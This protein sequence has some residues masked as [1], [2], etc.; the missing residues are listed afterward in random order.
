MMKPQ[1]TITLELITRRRAEELLALNTANRPINRKTV[2]SFASDMVAGRWIFNAAPVLVCNK[3][4][5]RD[6][7]HF[8][9]AIVVTEIPQWAIVVV[10]IDP[11]A[12]RTIDTGGKARTLTDVLK[13]LGIP[14]TSKV[15][16]AVVYETVDFN[17]AAARRSTDTEKFDLI[18]E[19]DEELLKDLQQ[20]AKAAQA[21]ELGDRAIV[22]ACFR[23]LKQQKE[24]RLQITPW[25]VAT[26]G[27]DPRDPNFDTELSS[28][29]ARRLREKKK[30]RKHQSEGGPQK[31]DLGL[32]KMLLNACNEY[33]S[34]YHPVVLAEPL[35]GPATHQKRASYPIDPPRAAT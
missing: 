13:L 26:L 10:G 16:Q 27:G 33:V 18:E 15:A 28:S 31:H 4:V 32:V 12:I 25:L 24:Y 30:R 11:R 5:L 34:R 23:A 8:L 2:E 21:N 3:G 6:K 20:I 17:L 29:L 35:T 22:G 19:V 14:T 7:Q 9:T 1:V